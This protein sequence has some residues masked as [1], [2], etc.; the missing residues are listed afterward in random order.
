MKLK[1]NVLL[2]KTDH[3]AGSFK[4][5]VEDYI[6]FFKSSQGSFKGEKKT[7]EPRTG[8]IDNPNERKNELVV[9]TVREKLD[10]MQES[11]GE[12]IDALFSQE[13]T[14]ASGVA[15][16]LLVVEGKEWGEFTSLE[17]L[18]LKSTLESGT[19]DDMYR[20]I[21]VRADNEI[22]NKSQNEMY[23]NRD[24]YETELF[25]GVAK[26]TVKEPY[27]LPDPNL[28][29]IKS[30]AS[31]LPAVVSK[32]TVMELADYTRQKFS[33]EW[34]HRERAELLRRKTVLIG[35]VIEA[36][37][38]AN[39]AEAIPSQLTATKIFDYLHRGK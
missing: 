24:I 19:L 32:D 3:L 2:A 20:N 25:K 6:K 18:K 14:N 33:G 34:S 12:Y 28:D 10:W 26:T 29:K 37:K 9:T 27:I 15:K 36:L 16:A 8:I 13:K 7:Y 11:F 1:L 5:S 31:Y 35:A 22:W 23:A 39:E 4:K 38:V 17:L 21:P 30:G